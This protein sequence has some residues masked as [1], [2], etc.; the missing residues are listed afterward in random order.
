MNRVAHDW[1]KN[2][3]K[4]KQCV[5]YIRAMIIEKLKKINFIYH[6]RESLKIGKLRYV[7]K[8]NLNWITINQQKK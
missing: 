4:K 2:G 7:E 3:A 1:F 8:Q 6:L 5:F